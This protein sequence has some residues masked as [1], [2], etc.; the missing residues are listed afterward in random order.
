[1]ADSGERSVMN[2]TQFGGKLPRLHEKT[3]RKAG[4]GV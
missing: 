3:R 4:F 2:C 1:L